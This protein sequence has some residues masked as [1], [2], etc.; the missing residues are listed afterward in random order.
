VIARPP[1]HAP[2]LSTEDGLIGF[3]SIA[4]GFWRTAKKLRNEALNRRLSLPISFAH[5]PRAGWP[6]PT[7]AAPNVLSLAYP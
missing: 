6:W 7:S 5:S 4:P 2:Y 1:Q 3:S